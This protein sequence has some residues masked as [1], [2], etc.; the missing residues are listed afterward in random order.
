MNKD[1]DKEIGELYIARSEGKTIQFIDDGGK[2]NE[3]S[4]I[5]VIKYGYRVKPEIQTVEEAAQ[6]YA[7]NKDQKTYNVDVSH[8]FQFGAQWQKE[9]DNEG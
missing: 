7:T 3:L 5:Q 9:Q 2:W 4:E 8:A 6:D 1:K